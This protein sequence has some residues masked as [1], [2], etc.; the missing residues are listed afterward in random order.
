MKLPKFSLIDLLDK[1]D[2][3][4][5]SERALFWWGLAILYAVFADNTYLTVFLVCAWVGAPIIAFLGLFTGPIGLFFG[6]VL[7]FGVLWQA[8]AAMFQP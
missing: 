1:V 5:F 3:C 7:Y 8:L 2:D 6:V 4:L